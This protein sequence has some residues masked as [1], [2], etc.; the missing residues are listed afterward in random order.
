MEREKNCGAK[1]DAAGESDAD[2]KRK[3]TEIE[4]ERESFWQR[5]YVRLPEKSV[6]PTRYIRDFFTCLEFLTRIRVTKRLS[7]FPDEFARSVPFFPLVGLLIGMLMQYVLLASRVL[8]LPRLATGVVL[9]G[10]ELIFIGSLLYDGYMD[11][12]DG[13]FSGR[14]RSRVLEI[15]QDSHVGAN[16]VIGI[17]FVL[18][19]KAVFWSALPPVYLPT[20]LV[21][22]YTATRTFMVLYIVHF[23]NARPGGLGAMFKEGAAPSYTVVAILLCA[24]IICSCGT[25]YLA[26]TGVT[27]ALCM[28]CALRLTQLL[29]GLTGDTF[30]FLTQLGEL[31]FYFVFLL[32]YEQDW[33]RLF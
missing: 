4:A 5:F 26:V 21:C 25:V 22:V 14:T 30:G 9:L 18:L 3:G 29:G 20:I 1:P 2:L 16:A 8:H 28:L 32:F 10:C 23:P 33:I 15:M 27:L 24:F 7:W 19:A 31:S 6:G 17:V 12:C 11:T 13:I